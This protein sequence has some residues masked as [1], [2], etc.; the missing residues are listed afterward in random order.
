M[1]FGR[2]WS[3]SIVHRLF[4]WLYRLNG[5]RGLSRGKCQP[6]PLNARN[7]SKNNCHRLSSLCGRNAHDAMQS[8]GIQ[9][10]DGKSWSTF[11]KTRPDWTLAHPTR[12]QTRKQTNRSKAAT[13]AAVKPMQ[14]ANALS[15]TYTLAIRRLFAFAFGKLCVSRNEVHQR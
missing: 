9:T 12:R 13:A 1:R 11:A 5:T 3:S 2:K 14:T 8:T 7:N 6:I 10:S 4:V 15:D